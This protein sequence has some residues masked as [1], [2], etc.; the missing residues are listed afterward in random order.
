MQAFTPK[1]QQLIVSNI[2]KACGDIEKL[3][4]TGYK[5]LY[6]CS[7]F[8]AHYDL[9]GFKSYY[10][11]SNLV[12]DIFAY[13]FM[14]KYSNFSPK[15]KDYEYYMSKKAIYSAIVNGINAKLEMAGML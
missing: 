12:H 8:I 7:G 14:N 4:F 11:E 3:N 6:L 2:I 5:F 10:T 9:Q 1:Q 15:D 13:Q